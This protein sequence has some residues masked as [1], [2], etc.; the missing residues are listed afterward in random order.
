MEIVK[1]EERIETR[2]KKTEQS[3]R[4]PWDTIQYINIGIVGIKK[5]KRNK[6]VEEIQEEIMKKLKK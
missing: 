1:S 6:G 2:L 3:I 5:E 4:N